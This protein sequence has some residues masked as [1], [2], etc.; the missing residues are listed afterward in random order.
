M[1]GRNVPTRRV[2]SEIHYFPLLCVFTTFR[3]EEGS[4]RHT[5]PVWGVG[6]TRSRDSGLFVPII[7]IYSFT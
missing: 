2:E 6:V 5:N 7:V 3:A 1:N 4:H